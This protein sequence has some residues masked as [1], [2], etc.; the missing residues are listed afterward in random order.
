[1]RRKSKFIR[2]EDMGIMG[3]QYLIEHE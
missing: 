3:T 1:V 2:I